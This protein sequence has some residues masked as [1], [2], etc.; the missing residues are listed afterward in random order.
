MVSVIA[1]RFVVHDNH[2][3]HTVTA[4]LFTDADPAGGRPC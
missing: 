2:G 3:G 1:H 4:E